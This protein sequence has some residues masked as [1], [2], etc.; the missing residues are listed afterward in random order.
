LLYVVMFTKTGFGYGQSATINYQPDY[1]HTIERYEILKAS[2]Y[3]NIFGIS[4]PYLRQQLATAAQALDSLPNLSPSDRFNITYLKNDNWEWLS[5]GEDSSSFS[6]KK[7][8]KIFFERK[9]DVYSKRNTDYDIHISPVFYFGTG[10]GADSSF[11]QNTRGIELRG[12]I[13]G[14]L[15]FYSQLTENQAILPSYLNSF[16]TQKQAIPGEGHYTVFGKKGV[17]YLSARGYIN[18]QLLKPVILTFGHDKS[19]LGV[20]YRSMLLSD[21]APPVLFFRINTQ[22]AKVQY[23]NQ[24]SQLSNYQNYRGQFNSIIPKKY[25]VSHQLNIK[26]GPRTELGFIEN[27]VLAR[28][29][30][31][32]LN[33]LNPIIFYRFAEVYLGSPDNAMVAAQFRHITKKKIAVYGQLLLDELIKNRILADTDNFA[34][35]WAYQIGVKA[36]NLFKIKNLDYQFEFNKIRPYTYSHYSSNSNYVHYNQA[37]AHPMGANLKEWVQVLRYQPWPRLSY[38][39]TFVNTAFGADINGQNWGGNPLLDY[40]LRQRDNNNFIGQGLTTRQH[41]LENRLSFNWKHNLFVDITLVYR[42]S[43][44]KEI[45]SQHRYNSLALRWNMPHKSFAL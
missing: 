12:S 21:F 34:N 43:N 36:A 8:W 32:D 42:S 29:T 20:G 30:D 4:K 13:G 17:D 25:M 26:T 37:L 22:I 27:V 3:K 44:T 24:Y 39:G 45:Y 2:T 15:G 5:P 23:I 11:W 41:F 9:S 1:Y 6:K 16:Y 19:F 28:K 10:R 33:Y 7:L 40:D 35:K 31:I 18:Y 14:K 38:V